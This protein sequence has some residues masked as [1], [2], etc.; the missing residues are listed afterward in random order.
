MSETFFLEETILRPLSQ[1]LFSQPGYKKAVHPMKVRIKL[2]MALCQGP[3]LIKGSGQEWTEILRNKFR[4]A[5]KK[6]LHLP[7]VFFPEQGAGAVN[8]DTAIPDTAGGAFQ[9][10]SLELY[11]G[12][13]FLRIFSPAGVRTASQNTQPRAGSINQNKIGQAI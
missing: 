6:V 11:K 10:F 9:N 4:V 1:S 8:Q 12:W 13:K 7:H 2:Q 5:G 3:F